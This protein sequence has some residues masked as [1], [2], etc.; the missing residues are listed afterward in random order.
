MRGELTKSSRKNRQGE[1]RL[2]RGREPVSEA[3]V[4]FMLVDP[5]EGPILFD[6]L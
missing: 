3:E 2:S 4:T 6:P 5:D 1:G